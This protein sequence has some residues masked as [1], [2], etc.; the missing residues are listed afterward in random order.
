MAA[1]AS[2][3]PFDH[4]LAILVTSK[5]FV[6]LKFVKRYIDILFLINGNIKSIMTF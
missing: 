6:V 5:A 3:S 2:K 4:I 1:H